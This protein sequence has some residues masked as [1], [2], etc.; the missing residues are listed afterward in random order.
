MFDVY[1]EARI[2]AVQVSILLASFYMY[3]ARPN[4]AFAVLGACIKSAQ[5]M[6][7]HREST[8]RGYSQIAREV[9][10]RTWW[11]IYIFDR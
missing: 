7:L 11:T 2:E 8:W 6:G 3:N 10:R 5:A 4:L 1:D 9:R